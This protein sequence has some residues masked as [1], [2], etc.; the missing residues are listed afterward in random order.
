MMI[1]AP[2]QNRAEELGIVVAI[3]MVDRWKGGNAMIRA[4]MAVTTFTVL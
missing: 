2:C 1:I 4:A 3:G